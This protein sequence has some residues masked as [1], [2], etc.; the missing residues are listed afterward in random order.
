M[1]ETS[2][3]DE[4]QG[5]ASP[6]VVNSSDFDDQ[7]VEER[8]DEVDQRETSVDLYIITF[9]SFLLLELSVLDSMNLIHIPLSVV[10]LYNVCPSLECLPLPFCR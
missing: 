6:D 7:A 9:V 4:N 5:T 2:S 10:S 8:S 3:V 1:D